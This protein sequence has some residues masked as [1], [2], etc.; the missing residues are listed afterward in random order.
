MEARLRAAL[1]SPLALRAELEPPTGVLALASAA[2]ESVTR[3]PGPG[4][5]RKTQVAAAF[6]LVEITA[7]VSRCMPLAPDDESRA[8]IE[9]AM[10]RCRTL[11]D[12]LTRDRRAL[13]TGQF[14]AYRTRFIGG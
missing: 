1:H 10:A 3:P 4:E 8:A 5:P 2:A 11:L 12:Q 7:L 6:Q 13:A 9:A 14:A